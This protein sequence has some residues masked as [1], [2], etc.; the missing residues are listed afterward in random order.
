MRFAPLFTLRLEHG[1]YQ[2]GRSRDFE[3][4]PT[5][6]C[7]RLLSRHK[8]KFIPGYSEWKVVTPLNDLGTAPLYDYSSDTILRF[9]LLLKN[10]KALNVSRF[11]DDTGTN[12]DFGE[13]MKRKAFPLWEITSDGAIQKQLYHY[14][15]TESFEILQPSEKEGF[16]LKGKVIPESDPL[17]DFRVE[18]LT[19][20]QEILEYSDEQ[21]KVFLRTSGFASGDTFSIQ[22]RAIPPWPNEVFGLVDFVY[23]PS[24]GTHQT[25]TFALDPRK[26]FVMY[27]IISNQDY[28][29]PEMIDESGTLNFEVEDIFSPSEND[30][31]AKW[32][33]KKYPDAATRLRFT[34]NEEHGMK[35]KEGLEIRF[36]RSIQ[37]NGDTI[38]VQDHLPSPSME[39]GEIQIVTQFS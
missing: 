3:F 18:G 9:F 14:W 28:L 24:I 15:E 22:F 23:N 5:K 4:V 39:Q 2:N 25:Q 8:M 6:G 21:N 7:W 36:T 17:S 37:V 13:W 30:S 20:G 27:Y 34:S 38:L 31:M 26:A 35:E 1:F 12:F 11:V 32:L 10:P 16:H 33:K 19:P 29:N